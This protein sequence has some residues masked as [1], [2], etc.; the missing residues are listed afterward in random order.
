MENLF[1]DV[2]AD[3][4]GYNKDSNLINQ[5]KETNGW[6]YLDG[7]LIEPEVAKK[8]NIKVGDLSPF[9]RLKVESLNVVQNIDI[10]PVDKKSKVDIKTKTE[11][12]VDIKVKT[13]KNTS[14]ESDIMEKSANKTDYVLENNEETDIDI[15]YV[16]K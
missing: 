14:V 7:F 5:A 2:I 1:L 9:T 11:Q 6:I 12:K 8:Y 10:I 15:K 16:K 3:V 13:E 4:E